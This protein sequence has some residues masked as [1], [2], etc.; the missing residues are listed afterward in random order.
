MIFERLCI[1]GV[2]LIGGSLS[3][4]LK[5]AGQVGEVVGYAR[6]A[7][8]RQQAL[9]LGVIDIAAENVTDAVRGADGV[10]LAV[11][12]GA[13]AS[14]LGEIAPHLSATAVITDGGSVKSPVVEAAALAL[15]DKAGQFVAGHPIAGTEKSGP[16]AAFATLYEEHQVILTPTD[17]TNMAAIQ[18]V[19]AMWEAVGAVVTEMEVAHHDAV[20]AATSHLPHVLAFNL[21]DILAQ[22]DDCQDVLRYAAGGFRDFSRI[23]SSDPV[24]WRDICVNNRDAMLGLL[25]EYQAGLDKIAAAIKSADE[26]YLL[27]VFERAKSARDTRF[28]K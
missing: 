28:T 17:K 10:F 27:S 5:Q 23:A 12:M 7:D 3:L 19:R 8:T 11:P 14:V 9:N 4:A 20:L 22:Q 24:M 21:V 16:A 25:T 6:S 13:M 15:G 18:T 1:I 26:D 2:G